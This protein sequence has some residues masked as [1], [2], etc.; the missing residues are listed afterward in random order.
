MHM[1]SITVTGF[2]CALHSKR[3]IQ[4]NY[5]KDYMELK[6]PYKT[7]YSNFYSQ[8]FKKQSSSS[9]WKSVKRQ[10]FNTSSSLESQKLSKP[11]VV[12]FHTHDHSTRANILKKQRTLHTINKS[13]KNTYNTATTYSH[14]ILKIH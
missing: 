6:L 12:Y 4:N 2:L 11:F 5:L 14:I 9:H 3:R 10:A 13:R 1:T 8:L 7:H